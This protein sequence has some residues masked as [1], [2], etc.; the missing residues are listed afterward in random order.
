MSLLCKYMPDSTSF[1]TIR[2]E[3]P[4][5]LMRCPDHKSAFW[6]SGVLHVGTVVL[7]GIEVLPQVSMFVQL[8]S[9]PRHQWTLYPDS[10][11]DGHD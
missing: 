5:T 11:Y 10:E 9:R 4:V 2:L 7:M 6:P 3:E 1:I 8:L